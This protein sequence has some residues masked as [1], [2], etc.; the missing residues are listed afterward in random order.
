MK[1]RIK[2]LKQEISDLE[3]KESKVYDELNKIHDEISKRKDQIN[4]IRLKEWEKN[5]S[6]RFAVG[7]IVFRPS[8]YYKRAVGNVRILEI[9]PTKNFG[10]FCFA[11]R[12]EKIKKD[13]SPCKIQDREMSYENDL[14]PLE[15]L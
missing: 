12:V 14:C 9:F 1:E 6:S 7:D 11:C 10:E 2:K 15:D 4:E 5:N 3:L 8:A 13:G